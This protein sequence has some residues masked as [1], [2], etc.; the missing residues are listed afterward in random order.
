ML[1]LTYKAP[2]PK[3]IVGAKHDWELVIGMEIHAQVASH[4]KLFSG[5][6]TGVGAEPMRMCLSLMRPCRACCL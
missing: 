1:D 3:I 5:A 2:K 6:S 4:A